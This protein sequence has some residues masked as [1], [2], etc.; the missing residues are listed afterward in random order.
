MPPKTHVIPSNPDQAHPL[1]EL[2]G[3]A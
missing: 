3:R 2:L 1:I